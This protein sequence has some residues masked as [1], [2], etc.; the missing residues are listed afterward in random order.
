MQLEAT[1]KELQGTKMICGVK[2]SLWLQEEN[3]F[4]GG[5][6]WGG[7]QRWKQGTLRKL[8]QKHWGRM[9]RSNS[10]GDQCLASFFFLVLRFMFQSVKVDCFWM[11]LGSGTAGAKGG[12]RWGLRDRHTPTISVSTLLGSD[13][14]CGEQLGLS[15]GGL[16][17]AGTRTAPHTLLRW[18]ELLGCCSQ[19]KKKWLLG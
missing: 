2:R 10:N 16:G 13:S 3:G 4:G 12:I 15:V 1:A 14:N 6:G 11:G 18:E 9:E 19:E 8:L 7:G 17:R 5:E